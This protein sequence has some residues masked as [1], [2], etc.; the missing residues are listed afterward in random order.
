[1]SRKIFWIVLIAGIII[2]IAAI[3][4]GVAAAVNS[5]SK[6]A[7]KPPAVTIRSPNA[8]RN[9]T[10]I[11]I[12]QWGLGEQSSY[13]YC[14]VFYQSISGAIWERSY[15]PTGGWAASSTMLGD[16]F[17]AR[18]GTP[19]CGFAYKD[20]KDNLEVNVYYVDVDGWLSDAIWSSATT[21][22][23]W[24]SGILRQQN[25]RVADETKIACSEWNTDSRIAIWLYYQDG[26]GYLQEFGRVGGGWR[27]PQY[28]Q[29]ID[30]RATMG[31]GIG[32]WYDMDE[33]YKQQIRVFV[34]IPDGTIVS[35]DYHENKTRNWDEYYP[36]YKSD[37]V[38]EKTD[39]A[40][41]VA[42][43]PGILK[44]TTVARVLFLE[45]T[46][47]VDQLEW[48]NKTVAWSKVPE[49]VVEE[50]DG[51]KRRIATVAELDEDMRCFFQKTDL[52]IGEAYLSGNS[53]RWA[54][55]NVKIE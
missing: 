40:V 54:V 4:G 10:A 41:A 22:T 29:K 43:T 27:E 2:I 13:S 3:G 32:V 42:R 12:A 37:A 23:G 38:L 19:I 55:Q 26:E 35:R 51:M 6:T 36:V 48:T 34:Q 33:F 46:G 24:K 30:L 20:K 25:R 11:G 1:V 7:E 14:Q 45:K 18:N 47:T 8:P 39:I 5:K 17:K 53:S 44:K 28:G 49:Y 50:T 21:P 15:T 16:G 52:S 9:G 31:S